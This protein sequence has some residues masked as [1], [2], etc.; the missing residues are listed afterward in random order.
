MHHLLN[1]QHCMGFILCTFPPLGKDILL[2]EFFK[3]VKLMQDIT[4]LSDD[5][6]AEHYYLGLPISYLKIHV[7]VRVDDTA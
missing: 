3:H 1:M 5:K 4:K 7:I 2:L 6:L